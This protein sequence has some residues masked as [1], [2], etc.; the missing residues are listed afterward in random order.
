MRTDPTRA[1]QA[2]TG[3]ART[4]TARTGTARTGTARR[5]VSGLRAVWRDLAG[6]VL[7][8]QCAGCGLDDEAWCG[9]CRAPFD[10]EPWRCEERAGRLDPI[11]ADA[12][13]V[14]TLADCVGPARAVVIAWKDRGRRDLTAPLVRA[15]ARVGVALAADL[16][17]PAGAGVLV[18]PAP[19]TSAARRRRGFAHADE[20]AR[21][22]AAGLR[23]AGV[24]ADELSALR[25]TG[26][27]QVGLGVRD[28]GRSAARVR[29]AARYRETVRGRAVVLVDDVL[30]SGATL[31]GAAR[32]LVA[33]G[34]VPLAAA[35]LASTPGPRAR[36]DE[37]PAPAWGTNRDLLPDP[38]APDGP[39]VVL[40]AA[41][42]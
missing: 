10:V 20:L 32:A 38:A 25:R 41:P 9:A 22:V 39:R 7:P 29:L 28:R 24:P 42:R 30:T 15:A 18:V 40:D 14:R 16:A 36:A 12:L 3:T 17:L 1:P 35:T 4:G 11:D 13:P 27:D 31:A 33:A 21:G 5:A 6:L 37:L 23:S 19:S 34:A 2:R 8:V 26:A